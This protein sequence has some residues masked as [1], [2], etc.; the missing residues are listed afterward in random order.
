MDD[1]LNFENDEAVEVGSDIEAYCTKCRMDLTHVVVAKYEDEVRRVQCNTCGGVHNYRPP[2][3]DA[4]DDG[5][6]P[7]SGKKKSTTKKINWED[8]TA[9]K[10]LN[11][12]KP[13]TFDMALKENEV[14]AHS[15]FGP[16][17]VTEIIAPTKAE[18]VF[19]DQKRILIFNRSD[20]KRKS[21]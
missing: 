11:A 15:T 8:L 13:Y 17:V 5:P 3:G 16:G 14:I 20:L 10:D 12:A 9:K 7:A 2:K 21:S 19:Q 1:E 4:D 18:V 6:E